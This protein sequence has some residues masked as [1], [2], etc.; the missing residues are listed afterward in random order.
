MQARVAVPFTAADLE[1]HDR[2]IREKVARDT[3]ALL[4]LEAHTN[5]HFKF[6]PVFG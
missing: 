3:K 1:A 2:D 6:V 4:E 5:G